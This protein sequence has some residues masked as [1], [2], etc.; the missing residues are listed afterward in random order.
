MPLGVGH[1]HGMTPRRGRCPSRRVGRLRKPLRRR[2]PG[3]KSKKGEQVERQPTGGRPERQPRKGCAFSGTSSPGTPAGTAA[4]ARTVRRKPNPDRAVRAPEQARR[5]TKWNETEP[6]R[7]ASRNKPSGATRIRA[8]RLRR[9]RARTLGLPSW[10]PPDGRAAGAGVSRRAGCRPGRSSHGDIP[11]A[12][13]AGA[14]ISRIRRG[15]GRPG[16][17]ASARASHECRGASG[18][19]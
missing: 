10:G 13:G 3:R 8:G 18:C 9:A 17:P 14:G 1:R 7:G 19:P 4:R 15:N 12:E 5:T 2:L 11:Y 16:C 6:E